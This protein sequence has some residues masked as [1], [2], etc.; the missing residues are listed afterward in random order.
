MTPLYYILFI[1]P[2]F[3]NATSSA[4][5]DEDSVL[6]LNHELRQK[7]T[8]EQKNANCCRKKLRCCRERLN[9]PDIE[10]RAILV[11]CP[12]TP[13][14]SEFA[15][16]DFS[17]KP[18]FGRHDDLKTYQGFDEDEPLSNSDINKCHKKLLVTM[19]IKNAGPTN[20]KNVFVVVDHV[21]DPTTSTTARLLNPYVIK[22]KQEPITALY[23]LRFQHVVNS[24]ARE[25][26]YN[27]HTSGY[28]G[29]D[30]TSATPTCGVVKYNGKIVPYSTGFCCSCDALVNS[31]RQP[32]SGI[33]PSNTVS[34]NNP[35]NIDDVQCPKNLKANNNNNDDDDNE[36]LNHDEKTINSLSQVLDPHQEYLSLQNSTSGVNINGID[37]MLPSLNVEKNA[38][39][40]E[41]VNI[42][43]VIVGD[44][45]SENVFIR[46]IRDEDDDSNLTGEKLKQKVDELQQLLNDQLELDSQA[47]QKV[48]GN[49]IYFI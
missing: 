48:L 21:Y 31:K 20:C 45:F 28:S 29:C 15:T 12:R 6:K 41:P 38:V 47:A 7:L 43:G 2:L 42:E 10:I 14:N 8:Q 19:K 9:P 32:D 24:E 49:K 1:L 23:K 40:D 39:K 13:C 16:Q 18:L 27:K 11:R 36:N 44:P 3:I 22:I 5:S 30:T 4:T 34:S 25:M 26:V 33:S 35:L 37:I 17:S 46:E